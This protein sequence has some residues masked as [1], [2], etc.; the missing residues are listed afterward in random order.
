M[1]LDTKKDARKAPNG[2]DG[3]QGGIRTHGDIAATHAFQACSFDHSDTCPF[4]SRRGGNLT[5]RFALGNA[6]FRG[7]G[8]NNRRVA[9]SRSESRS[10]LFEHDSQSILF[11]PLRSPRLC[12][13]NIDQ[14]H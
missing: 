8:R 6:N 9:E 7:F 4:F 2:P 14:G 11:D 3:G 1:V 5:G 10:F 13:S 12:G